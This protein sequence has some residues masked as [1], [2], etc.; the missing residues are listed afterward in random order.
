MKDYSMLCVLLSLS[1]SLHLQSFITFSFVQLFLSWLSTTIPLSQF[2]YE[3]KQNRVKWD[4][5]I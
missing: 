5:E 1:L 3:Y 4:I 2:Q